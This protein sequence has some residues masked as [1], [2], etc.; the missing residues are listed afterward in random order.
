MMRIFGR[1]FSEIGLAVDG[2]MSY[3]LPRAV[4]YHKAMA[5]TL[6]AEKIQPNQ[7]KDWGIVY[8]VVPRSQ[9]MASAIALADKLVN[10]S[11]VANQEIKMLHQQSFDN[12]FIH[13][14]Q[15]ECKSQTKAGF[16]SEARDAIMAFLKK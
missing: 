14:M 3:L 4:G 7:A 16:S 8:E 12:D 9:L 1:T 15:A 2:G 11:S 13:Q 6:L 5:M 10:R